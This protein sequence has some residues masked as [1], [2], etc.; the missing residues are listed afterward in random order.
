MCV[1]CVCCVCM[2]V[3]CVCVC[4]VCKCV[5]Y[6]CRLVKELESRMTKAS[7]QLQQELTANDKG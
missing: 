6:L 1:L 2:S 4:C 5:H 3:L 7:E